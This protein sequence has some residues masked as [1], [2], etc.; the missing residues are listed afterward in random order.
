MKRH[1]LCAL[2]SVASAFSPGLPLATVRAASATTRPL[3]MQHESDEMRSLKEALSDAVASAREMAHKIGG[4]S[5]S[6]SRIAAGAIDDLDDRIDRQG[7]L[8][9][10]PLDEFCEL[11]E[12]YADS[13]CMQLEASLE[14]VRDYTA[15][16]RAVRDLEALEAENEALRATL[17]QNRG[18]KK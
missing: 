9:F 18:G 16:V 11:L 12:N 10:A 15:Q 13:E 4:D 7:A 2:A 14:R 8:E 6:E 3:F 5:S 1:V 17:E